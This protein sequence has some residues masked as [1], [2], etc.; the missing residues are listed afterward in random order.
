[1]KNA[2]RSARDGDDSFNRL[3]GDHASSP[4]L[5]QKGTSASQRVNTY[6]NLFGDS[7]RPL[8][9]STPT[10]PSK[11]HEHIFGDQTA[12]QG[13]GATTTGRYTGKG[14]GM[15]LPFHT[16]TLLT[17]SAAKRDTVLSYSVSQ[18]L[19]EKSSWLFLFPC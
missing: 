10:E 5:S 14:R 16:C 15:Q 3:F 8:Q 9:P 4:A 12:A 17:R 6:D 13:E 18:F 7:R 1:M 11:T 2:Q 19:N